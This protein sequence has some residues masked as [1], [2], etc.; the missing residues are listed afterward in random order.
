MNKS[1]ALD[2]IEV[3]DRL[4]FICDKNFQSI[5]PQDESLLWSGDCLKINLKGKRQARDFIITDNKVYNLGKKSNFIFSIFSKPVKRCFKI[6]DIK[7]ITYSNISNNFIM[8][9]PNEYDYYLC[10]PDKDEFIRYLLYV[11]RRKKLDPLKFYMVEDIDLFKHNRYEGQTQEKFPPVTP[12][13]FDMP[14]FVSLLKQKQKELEDNINKTEVIVSE[15]GAMINE[16][17][18][19]ILKTLGK[20]YFGR[21]FL[22]E[23]KDTKN[24]YALKVISKL[25]IIKRNF[26]DNLKSEKKI[27]QQ[28]KNPF[29]VNLEYC[30]ASPSYVFFAMKFK[31]GGELYY[32]LRKMTRFPESTTKFYACQIIQGLAYLHSMN[33]MYRDMKPE[34]V[35]LDEKGNACLADFG[36]SKVLNPKEMAKSFVGTPEYVAP[37]IVLQKGHNKAVDIWCFGVLLYEMVFGIPPFYNKNQNVMLNWVVKLEPTFPKMIKISDELTSLI[38]QVT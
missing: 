3:K 6:E 10:T 9:I 15:D 27:M 2:K 23:K 11:Q 21:V 30:F 31:Q 14:N 12:Q 34:N 4:N 20:G 38:S 1:D 33:I 13:R 36:I 35:L 8:H 29:V 26:F 25:D 24:L 17:S 19:E 16:N 37:E 5:I 32:H 28:I 18:F 22:V 7:A